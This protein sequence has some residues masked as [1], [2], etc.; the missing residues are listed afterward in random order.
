MSKIKST[1]VGIPIICA[2]CDKL[3]GRTGGSFTLGEN[4]VV[5]KG[6]IIDTLGCNA[7]RK[8]DGIGE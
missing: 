7:C 5:S 2:K 3:I 6:K 4:Q 8:L 1:T